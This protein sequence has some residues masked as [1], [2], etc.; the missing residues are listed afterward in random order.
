M[1]AYWWG[2]SLAASALVQAGA[3][4]EQ[5]DAQ[6]NNAAWYARRFGKGARQR[7]MEQ[8]IDSAERRISMEKILDRHQE[9]AEPAER[10]LS[11]RQRRNSM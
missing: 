3:V 10:R 9:A 5:T 11:A 7:E 8:V 4:Y 6:G 2:H 1:L